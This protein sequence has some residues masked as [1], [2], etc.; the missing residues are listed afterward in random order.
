MFFLTKGKHKSGCDDKVY[1]VKSYSKQY[2]IIDQN[3][4]AFKMLSFLL[5]NT[6]EG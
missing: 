5:G 4:I 1:L 3:R 6:Y 2:M